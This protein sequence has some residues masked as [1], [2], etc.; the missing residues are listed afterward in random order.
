ML[1]FWIIA[2]LMA[3]AASALM[4]VFARR[5]AGAGEADPTMAVFRRQLAEVDEMAAR[6]LLSGG[7]REAARAEAGR[8]LLRAA[9]RRPPRT[10][11]ARP[12]LLPAAAGAAPMAAMGLYLLLGSAGAGDQPF[13]ARL[14]EWRAAPEANGPA[15][16]AAVMEQVVRE[17]PADAEAQRLLG[18]ARLAAGDATGAV[19]ALEAAARASPRRAEVWVDLAQALLA[20][21]PPS[22]EDAR[23]ALA[24]ALALQPA[25]PN[26]RYWLGA[27]SLAEGRTEEGLGQWR[28]LAAELPATDPR[29]SALLAEIQAASGS[30]AA[31]DINAMVAGLA[32]RLREQPDDPAGWARLVRAYAVLGREADLREALEQARERFGG[33]NL[34]RIEAEAA[35]GRRLQPRP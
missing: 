18:R 21:Q 10:G 31:P 15:E 3:A 12:W 27:T 29:R 7:E 6:G 9:D 11:R 33:Q 35:A 5:A 26:A 16:A 20:L 4:L 8:R 25:D 28:A 13:A 22:P 30:A 17:R 2:A 34:A 32:A 1:L 24:Q 23:R 14:R 19:A